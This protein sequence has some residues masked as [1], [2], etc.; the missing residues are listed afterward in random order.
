MTSTRGIST[1]HAPNWRAQADCR[2]SGMDPDL[3]FPAGTTGHYLVQAYEAKRFCYACPVAITCALWAIDRKFDDGI[4][5][6]LSDKQRRTLARKAANDGLTD[7]EL[8]AQV[9]A[10]WTRD[11]QGP[12]VT[13]YLAATIQGNDGHVWWRSRKNTVVVAG[14]VFTP[15]QLAFEV[16]AGRRAEGQVKATCGQ[17]HCAAPEHLADSRMRSARKYRTTAA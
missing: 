10:V 9:R 3:W 6:G 13:A 1:D 15:A 14:R 17:P 7:A 4:F 5:G 16:G 11:A 8:A 2:K 12:L